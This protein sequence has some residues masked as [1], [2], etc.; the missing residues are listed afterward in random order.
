MP[1]RDLPTNGLKLPMKVWDAP[2]RLFH[3]AVVL[4]VIV[5]FITAQLDWMRA[6]LISGYIML[7]ALLFRLAW[8]FAGSETARFSAFL[9]SP[10]A[11]FRHIS[12][13]N[14]REPDTQIGHNAAGGW[15]VLIMLL[16][17]YIQVATGLGAN[18]DHGTAGPLAK[19]LGKHLSNQIS[20]VH[21]L[22]F[23][24]L[25]A[26]IVVHLLAIAAYAQ[27]K[28]QNLLRPMI[29][30]KKRLPGAMRA[31][32]MATPLRALTVF[33]TAAIIAVL[34]ATWL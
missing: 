28:G 1:R 34:I 23:W 33:F 14:R 5:S 12:T 20:A 29:T 26:A 31:P 4:L 9:V 19:Y 27:L 16:L 17:L 18:D 13:L 32:R 7:T 21:S 22:S 11:G 25:V 24:L 10:F 2:T 30:G 8:G 15:M 6:H 3:W